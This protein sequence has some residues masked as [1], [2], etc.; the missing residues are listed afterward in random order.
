MNNIILGSVKYSAPSKWKEIEKYHLKIW[1]KI[2]SLS[3]TPDDAF[4]VATMLFYKIPKW[5]FNRL[6]SA[7]RFDL[8]KT[9]M[10]LSHRNSLTSWVIPRVSILFYRFYGPE[11]RLTNCTIEEYRHCE[12]YYNAYKRSSDEKYLDLLLSTLYRP[13][14]K[15]GIGN[16]IRVQ[17]SEIGLRRN[18][19]YMQRLNEDTRQS[20]LFNYEGCRSFICRKYPLIFKMGGEQSKALADLEQ[21]I[22]IVAGGK[23]GSFNETAQTPLYLFLSHLSD[24]IEE[25]ENIK[26][27]GQ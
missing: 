10:F 26:K 4:A 17:L 12:L 15:N 21:Q 23:F 25:F 14:G 5:K 7:Q 27:R 11:N 2:L 24:E 3:I 16:D 18:A 8:V 1:V 9:I 22:K 13:K 6:N 20:I 19:R